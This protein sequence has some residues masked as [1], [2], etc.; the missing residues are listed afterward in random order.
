MP[1]PLSTA[2]IVVFG[3]VLLEII[4]L[5]IGRFFKKTVDTEYVTVERCRNCREECSRTRTQGSAGMQDQVRE[6]GK[7]IDLL[8][9]VL[10]VVAVKVGAE[11]HTLEKLAYK[12]RATDE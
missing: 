5:T 1:E 2:V 10:L 6:L 9:G 12:R 8:R 4:K 3:Y 7:S 11:D